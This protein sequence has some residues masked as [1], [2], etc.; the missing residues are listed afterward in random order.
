[1]AR[2]RATTVFLTVRTT[3]VS[4]KHPDARCPIADL[5][6]LSVGEYSVIY[7]SPDG[8]QH[9]IGFIQIPRL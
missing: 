1:M 2:V 9:P 7:L 4:R 5:G 8:S 6:A 3:I